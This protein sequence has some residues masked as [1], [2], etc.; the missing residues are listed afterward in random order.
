M[1]CRLCRWW[2]LQELRKVDALYPVR[3]RFYEDLTIIVPGFYI[4]GEEGGIMLGHGAGVPGRC[5]DAA[6]DKRGRG[7]GRK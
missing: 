6:E 2:R 4:A 1:V 3:G 7:E 5:R